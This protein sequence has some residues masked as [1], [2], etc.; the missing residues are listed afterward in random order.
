M[1]YAIMWNG[2]ICRVGDHIVVVCFVLCTIDMRG[3]GV[4]KYTLFR[5]V[6]NVVFYSHALQ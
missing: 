1:L 4:V 3:V 6:M 5:W 2:V